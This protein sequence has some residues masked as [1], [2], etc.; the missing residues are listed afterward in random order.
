MNFENE[1]NKSWLYENLVATNFLD[2]AMINKRR[3]ELLGRGIIPNVAI[4]EDTNIVVVVVL[5]T[6]PDDW[7]LHLATLRETYR[8]IHSVS[9]HGSKKVLGAVPII[10]SGDLSLISNAMLDYV[11]DVIVAYP[12]ITTDINK[13]SFISLLK[14]LNNEDDAFFS[15]E[16]RYGHNMEKLV[17]ATLYD[18]LPTLKKLG[19]W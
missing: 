12:V 8:L 7:E 11:S 9:E 10:V 2:L 18:C 19:T 14:E 13:Y 1:I 3:T 5:D 16:I 6:C 4:T 17:K 15:R